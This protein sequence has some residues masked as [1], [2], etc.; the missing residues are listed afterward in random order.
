MTEPPDETQ[1]KD[2]EG[3]A[4]RWS[5]RKT[6]ERERTQIPDAAPEPDL[7]SD[8]ADA[9]AVQEIAPEDLPDIETLDK[10][11]DYTPFLQAGVPDKLRRLAF[12]KLWLSDP[13]FGNLDGLNDYDED[14]SAI[15][16]VAKEIVSRYKPGQGMVDE[17]EP[18]IS[19]EDADQKMQPDATAEDNAAEAEDVAE[20]PS[21]DDDGEPEPL[22]DNEDGDAGENDD[23]DDPLDSSA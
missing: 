13:I 9:G 2:G 17:E 22:S 21:E 11:S 16:I 6:Q 4:T 10:E 23:T 15:G 8:P 20:A 1:A 5:R 7:P 18:D 19:P 12:R 3:F 14:Y